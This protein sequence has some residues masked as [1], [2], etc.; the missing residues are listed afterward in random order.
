[1][2]QGGRPAVLIAEPRDFSPRARRILEEAADVRL[3][4][5]DGEGL[6]R[7]MATYDVVWIRL[8]RRITSDVLGSRPRCRI[9]AT[10][11]TGLDHIDLEACGRL[12][13]R[14]VSLRGETEFL[15]SVR[16]TAEHTLALTLAL[17]RRVPAAH[18]AAIA[19]EWDRD[20]FRGGELFE[21]TVGIVGVGRLGSLIAGYF[22]A[23]GAQVI[24]CDP[25]SD[26]PHEAATR[27]ANLHEL[28]A[29]SDIVCLC[30]NYDASTHR[31]IGPA[32]FAAMKRTAMLVNTSRGGVIDEQA[33]LEALQSGRLAGAALDV[34]DGEP[35][36]DESHPIVRYAGLHDN[37][38]L[39]PH[40]GGNTSESLDKTETFLAGR[41]VEALRELWPAAA[42][43]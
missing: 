43:L 37:V 4:A 36:I 20:R 32:E 16:A 35:A 17:L 13:I 11:T 22:R 26:Y 15:R 5:V 40:L 29:R 42:T 24:G 18:A 39:T 3:E 25:R 2:T 1:M 31:L 8:A 19:G 28:L 6:A 10:A 38:V 9:L 21:K 34:L 27:I 12:G 30:V 33:L 41:V 14:V 23:L 7:G